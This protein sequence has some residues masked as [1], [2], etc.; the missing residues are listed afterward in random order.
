MNPIAG[1][2]KLLYDLNPQFRSWANGI[3]DAIKGGFNNAIAFITGLPGEALGWGKD[4]IMGI[5]NGIK[6]AISDVTSAVGD[7]AGVIKSFLHF[8]T[9]DVGPL[10]NFHAWPKDM[11]TGMA[12]DILSSKS[13]VTSG[14]SMQL[15]GSMTMAGM[16]ISSAPTSGE[17]ATTHNEIN[18]NGSY[19][20]KNEADIK[21]FLNQAALIVRRRQ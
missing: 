1:A 15:Q 18:F 16:E 3:G 5:V 17:N 11:M 9:P 20:F 13:A 2:V 19:A 4:I 10:V 12:Q 7:A 21:T 14:M 8:S 6:S